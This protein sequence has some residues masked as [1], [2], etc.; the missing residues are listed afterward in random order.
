MQGVYRNTSN[1]L[2][3]ISLAGPIF[4]RR[5]ALHTDLNFQWSGSGN[6]GGVVY[7]YVDANN[8]RAALMRAV[9]VVNGVTQ[10]GGI[11]LIE[12]RN[13]VRTSVPVVH[14]AQPI[15]KSGEW[16][17]LSVMR[18]G[19]VTSVRAARRDPPVGFSGGD[20]HADVTQTEL[21]GRKR[22]GL[23]ASWNLIRFDDAVVATE[24]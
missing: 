24:N 3:A 21:V 5:Y 6:R 8:Y 11:E 15:F 2:A 17:R 22:A 20:F 4:A 14:P 16:V 7:D 12:V 1:Q 10:G 9:R 19:D 13:G 18:F 23:L